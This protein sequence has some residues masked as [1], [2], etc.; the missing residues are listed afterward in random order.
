LAAIIAGKF[1]SFFTTRPA[2]VVD[3]E[4]SDQ[5]ANPVE[6][7]GGVIGHSPDN[8]KVILI[9]SNELLQDQTT[10]LL[11]SAQGATYLNA[12]QLIT[13]AIDW[14]LEDEGLLKIRARGHFNQTLPP[15]EHSE[16]LFWEYGHYVFALFVIGFMVFIRRLILQRKKTDYQQRLVDQRG[17]G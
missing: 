1:E 4:K 10:R 12:Y 16:Q 15:M 13:N 17:T 9:A 11:T 5:P 14:S 3:E 8:A 2:P 6:T 7:Y